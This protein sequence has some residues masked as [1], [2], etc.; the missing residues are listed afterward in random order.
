MVQVKRFAI[1]EMKRTHK[2]VLFQTYD[3]YYLKEIKNKKDKKVK[4]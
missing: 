4:F 2:E 3:I 1:S